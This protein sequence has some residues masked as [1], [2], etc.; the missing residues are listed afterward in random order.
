ME[1]AQHPDG[2]PLPPNTNKTRLLAMAGV[3]ATVVLVAFDS[4]IVANMLPRAAQALGGMSLY[5]WAGTGY[6]LSMAASILVFGRIGDLYGRREL[7][8][9]SVAIVAF[10]SLMCGFAGSMPQLIAWRTFQGI[11]GGMMIATAFAAPA[12]L[13]PDVRERVQWMAL[14][15]VTFAI[16]SGIGPVLG[17]AITQELGWRAAFFV[18]PTAGAFALFMLFRFFPRIA[19]PTPRDAR[20]I[21]WPGA[22]LL[23]VAIA[24]PL[25]ALELGLSSGAHRKP[26]LAALLT[27]AGL[28]A[29]L[30]FLWHT[31]R[32]ASPIFPPRVLGTRD[33][34]LLNLSAIL[35]GAIMF[36]LIFYSPL[37]LQDTLGLRPG[38]AGLLMT[39]LVVGIP[40]GSLVNGRL[41][42][43]Q[44]QPQRLLTFGFSALLAG[45]LM[46]LTI[47]NDSGALWILL[48]FSMAGFGLGFILPNLTLFMQMLSEPRDI[49][50]SSG[51]VQTTRAIGSA[52]GTAAIGIVI[53]RSSVASGIQA[54]LI[55]CGAMSIICMLLSSRI[56]MRNTPR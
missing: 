26:V 41:F 35:V 28:V 25:A 18:T 32:A 31:K 12:D 30:L 6:L 1:Q 27:L 45:C 13:F 9:L 39:P 47:G 10:G 5:A 15:S 52:L 29:A 17:G 40:V 33:A 20:H 55:A 48:S 53:A 2:N 3:A 22:A 14:V 51:L 19:S 8:L 24:S 34:R 56:Q 23:V 49:G 42:P 36:I 43:L 11:G 21:D 38:K 7:M 46:I 44:K 16:A 50:V 54:G 37:M 4:T